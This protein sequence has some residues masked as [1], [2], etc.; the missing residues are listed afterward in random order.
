MTNETPDTQQPET[1]NAQIEQ[2]DFAFALKFNETPT[3]E[4]ICHAIVSMFQQ[5]SVAFLQKESIDKACMDLRGRAEKKLIFRGKLNPE[6]QEIDAVIGLYR[7]QPTKPA[8]V[9]ATTEDLSHLN[10]AQRRQIERSRK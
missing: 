7:A 1:P 5:G 4:E 2:F 10:R 3:T 8:L 6:K 9:S